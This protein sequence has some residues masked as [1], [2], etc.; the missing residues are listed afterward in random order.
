MTE[1]RGIGKA[2][3]EHKMTTS[4][5]VMSFRLSSGMTHYPDK[6]GQ[7]GELCDVS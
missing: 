7:V 6:D 3:K 5:G 2:R 1:K 4:K